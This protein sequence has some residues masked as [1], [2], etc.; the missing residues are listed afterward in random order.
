M[1]GLALCFLKRL[2]A[3]AYGRSAKLDEEL[4]HS[5]TAMVDRLKIGEARLVRAGA[6][7]KWFVYTDAFYEPETLTG[8]LG[9]VLLDS[10]GKTVSWFGLV[11]TFDMCKSLGGSVKK[12]LIY[13]L[14]LLAAVLSLHLWCKNSDSNI[15]VWFQDND[16]VRYAHIRASGSGSVAISLLKFHLKDE[17]ERDSL[18]WF[19]RVPTEAN[20]SDFPSMLVEHPFL[21]SSYQC[22]AT[23]EEKLHAILAEV[24]LAL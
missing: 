14:E 23:A 24:H 2:S 21:E 22:N 11:L 7:Q 16:S 19:A 4:V 12:T 10:T 1:E 6:K 3:H 8:G 18:I 20:I 5:L 9:G 17:A 13:K 15:H